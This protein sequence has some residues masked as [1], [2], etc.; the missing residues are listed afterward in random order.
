MK[1]E[2]LYRRG[3]AQNQS[4]SDLMSSKIHAAASKS[5]RKG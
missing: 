2:W 3:E 4:G 1:E 5:A